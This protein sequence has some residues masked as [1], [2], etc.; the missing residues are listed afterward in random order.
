MGDPIFLDCSSG[1]SVPYAVTPAVP[2]YQTPFATAIGLDVGIAAGSAGF[3][4]EP[5][6][7]EQVIATGLTYAVILARKLL[8]DPYWSLHAAKALRVE[9]SRPVRYLRAKN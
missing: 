2:G 7:A 9:P 6:Q 5:A 8:R 4:T 1:G 3:I